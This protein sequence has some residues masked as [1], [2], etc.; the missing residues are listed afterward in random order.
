MSVVESYERTDFD[1]GLI[2][3]KRRH[4][5]IYNVK[6]TICIGCGLF[7]IISI[8]RKQCSHNPVNTAFDVLRPSNNPL[9]GNSTNGFRSGV[10]GARGDHLNVSWVHT[11][12]LEVPE[13]AEYRPCLQQRFEKSVAKILTIRK[14][15]DFAVVAFE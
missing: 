7:Q 4:E 6:W 2:A 11:C 5:A 10:R 3:A 8:W 12:S 15:P 1:L 9:P 13:P 14:L